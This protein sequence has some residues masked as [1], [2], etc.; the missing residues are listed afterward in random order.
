MRG[1]FWLPKWLDIGTKSVM[2]YWNGD[3]YQRGCLPIKVTHKLLEQ[4]SAIG[5]SKIDLVSLKK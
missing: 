5:G 1:F 2:K 3:T 4:L